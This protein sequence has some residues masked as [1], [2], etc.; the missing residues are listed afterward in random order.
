M[1]DQKELDKLNQA[2]E[3]FNRY[4]QFEDAVQVSKENKEY[5]KTYIHLPEYVIKNFN[6]KAKV[7]KNIIVACIV[8]AALFL[9]LFICTGF[10]VSLI[11]IPAIGFVL[12]VV[13][14]TIIGYLMNKYRLSA[15]L[16]HQVEI[17]NGITEQ[18]QLLEERIKQ[19]EKQS[20]DYYR[21]L[22]RRITFISL[23][24][25]KYI[26]KIKEILVSG[27]ADTCEEAIAI[28]EQQLLM[29]KMTNTLNK[30]AKYTDE[31]NKARFGDPVAAIM[32]NKKKK[33]KN[34]FSRS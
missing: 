3:Y 22:G 13:V 7:T 34:L 5:L 32:A 4:F 14:G 11:W 16:Q 23:D 25:M 33:K 19:R 9:L 28:F 1:A 18:I 12:S 15:A 29:K 10:E 6:L 17:N 26:P 30:P 24:Y 31:E 2:E 8:G 21:E 20:K 27:E